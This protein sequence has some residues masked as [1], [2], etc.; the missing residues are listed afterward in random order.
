MMA[1]NPSLEVYLLDT[2]GQILSYVVFDKKVKLKSVSLEP[3]LQFI[4]GNGENLILG[5][6]PRHPKGSTIFSA[7]PVYEND[8]L[9]GYVYMVLVSEKYENISST[10]LGSY[11]I[12]L[13]AKLLTVTFLAAVVI[14]LVLIW[15][16]TRNLRNILK[17]F[18]QFEGGDLSVRI[19][20][21]KAKGELVV[22]ARTFNSMAD[23]ILENIESLKK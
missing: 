17:A 1:V 4:E 18:K 16:L 14:G 6:D 19:P 5:D 12:T 7:T 22:L 11:A 8:V 21:E 15:L 23:K 13:S 3:V 2:E 10:L 9:M 20:E